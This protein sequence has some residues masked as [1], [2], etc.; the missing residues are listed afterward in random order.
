METGP[1]TAMPSESNSRGIFDHIRFGL[2]GPLFLCLAVAMLVRLSVWQQAK[3]DGI[4]VENRW[5][6]QARAEIERFRGGWTYSLQVEKSMDRLRR[7]VSAKLKSRV[8]FDGTTFVS[9]F[10]KAVPA[11]HRPPGSLLFAFRVHSDGRHESLSAQGLETSMG[12][13]VGNVLVRALAPDSVPPAQ[14]A[15]L[16]RQ[17]TGLFGELLSFDVIARAR[18][19]RLTGARWRGTDAL[20][21]WNCAETSDGSIVWLALFPRSAATSAKPVATALRKSA[22]RGKGAMWPILVP[23]SPENGALKLRV[24]SGSVPTRIL[25][26]VRSAIARCRTRNELGYAGSLIKTIPGIL[27]MRDV[28]A[29]SLPYELW[30]V[31]PVPSAARQASPPWEKA[32]LAALAGVVGLIAVRS[33]MNPG[34]SDL[35]LRVWFTG[36]VVLVG[37]VPL[38]LVWLLASWWITMTAE[39]RVGEIERIAEERLVRLDLMSAREGDRFARLCS[40]VLEDHALLHRFIHAPPASSG[41]TLFENELAALHASGLPAEYMHVFRPGRDSF[42]IT[43]AGVNERPNRGLFQLQAGLVNMGVVAGDKKNADYYT[44]A[45]KPKDRIAF[46]G[47]K[48]TFSGNFGNNYYDVRRR[49]HLF[50]GSEEPLFMTYDFISDSAGFQLCVIFAS[51]ARAAFASLLSQELDRWKMMLPG[52]RLAYGI[53]M[54]GGFEPLGGSSMVPSPDMTRALNDATRAGTLQINRYGERLYIARPCQRMPGFI[55]GMEFST[56][57]IRREASRSLLLLESVLAGI[58]SLLLLI[59]L[60]VGRHLLQPLAGLEIGLRRAAAGDLETR[61]GLERPDEIGEVTRAF[62]RMIDGLRERRELGRFVSATLDHD[63]SA[64]NGSDSRPREVEGT[65]LVSDLRS[66]TT[67]SESY[68]VE[69]V[70]EMLNWHLETMAGAIHEAGGKIDRFIGDAVIAAFY[71]ETPGENAAR[72]LKAAVAMIRA[73]RKRQEERRNRGVFEYGMGVGIDSGK[74]LVGSFGTAERMERSLLGAPRDSAERLEA[75]S[76]LGTSTTI[77]LSNET[78]L[79]LGGPSEQFAKIAKIDAWEL[80]ELPPESAS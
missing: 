25:R 51:R 55:V 8:P 58:V 34:Q 26:G 20:M 15:S 40:S 10:L 68:P 1:A 73:H 33:M 45:L 39:R 30:L 49:G 52:V 14:R 69:E 19:G 5:R 38:G 74:L 35:S 9:L 36:Y 7:S 21:T 72:S 75:G 43:L 6:H 50:R 41:Q 60:G 22:A 28:I 24:A 2:L 64:V 13:L 11:S 61:V 29:N 71:G 23:L 17:S 53:P 16:D 4:A 48:S 80:I 12:R 47:I 44:K 54:P 78:V 76:K 79:L 18:R 77:I 59:G 31:G 42:M 46:D 56:A 70:V 67:I 63:V 32:L 66:F 57:G 27:A 65:V 37:V 3:L 62:D